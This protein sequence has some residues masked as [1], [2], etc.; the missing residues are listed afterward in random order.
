MVLT[1]GYCFGVEL[2]VD[3]N[4]GEIPSPPQHF[5]IFRRSLCP[6]W[7]CC[8]M[9]RR[10]LLPSPPLHSGCACVEWGPAPSL[11][12]HPA[13]PCPFPPSLPA[14]SSPPPS[15]TATYLGD[16]FNLDLGLAGVLGS[17]FGLSNLFAR[18]LGGLLSDYSAKRFGMRG[19]LWTLWILQTMGGVCALLMYQARNSLGATMGVVVCWAIFVPAACGGTFGIA[20][21]I[22][23][24]G[25]G[26]ALGLIGSGGNAG[27]SITQAAFFTSTSMTV[28][29]GFQWM[30]ERQAAHPLLA[31]P[32]CCWPLPLPVPARQPAS[33]PACLPASLHVRHWPPA[34]SPSLALTEHP[35]PLCLQA[36]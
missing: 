27:S 25:L 23:R 2:T 12:T 14:R 34:V 7:C 8:W 16:E 5:V 19:R 29:E 10:L 24:R 35:T 6:V 18:A 13:H 30:G 36:A 17:V 21:F 22:T 1:Y 11:P 33:L 4:I 15:P 3:N 31:F 20:P 26:V 28:A 9:P 32:S